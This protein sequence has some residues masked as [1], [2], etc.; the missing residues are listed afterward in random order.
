MATYATYR[1]IELDKVGYG[2]KRVR[3]PSSDIF[4]VLCSPSSGNSTPQRNG[5]HTPRRTHIHNDSFNRLFGTPEQGSS[6]PR[7]ASFNKHDVT[8]RNPVTGDGVTSWD[9]K[10]I[11]PKMR[12]ERNPVTGEYYT[13]VSPA[14]TPT[15]PMQNGFSQQN[16]HDATPQQNGTKES[17]PEKIIVNGSA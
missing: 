9:Q 3:N 7:R 16:G 14:T 17:T 10:K 5:T 13:I 6:T 2:K 8:N 4:N 12:T 1:H 15:K 11:S